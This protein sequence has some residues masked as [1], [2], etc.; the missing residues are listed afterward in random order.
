MSLR[1]ATPHDSVPLGGIL[2]AWIQETD[3][4]PKL[5]SPQVDVAFL[6]NTI[7]EQQVTV[8][9]DA[10]GIPQG[11]IA[12]SEGYV[13]CLYVAQAAR[14]QGLGAALLENVKAQCG[15][16][17]LWTHAQNTGARRFYARHGFAQ[18]DATEGDN[19][20]GLPDVKLTWVRGAK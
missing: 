9:V 3:W 2:S 18:T 8:S 6:A 1:A 10:Q 11:F 16:L 7:G 5:R 13:S 4:M 20:E 12:L 17:T 19:A 14:S 15:Q